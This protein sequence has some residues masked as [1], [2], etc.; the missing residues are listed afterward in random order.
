[1]TVNLP[2][3]PFPLDW[4]DAVEPPSWQVTD[5]GLE[6]TAAPGTDWYVYAPAPA[7]HAPSNGARLLGEPPAG[8]W[9]FSA[10]I[11]VDFNGTYDAG[12]LFLLADESHWSKLCFEYSPD[13]QGM[14]VS[15]VTRGISDDANAWNV[16][17]DTVWMRVS[18]VGEGF[19]FHASSDG[20][21]W[22]FVRCF[23]FGID[24]PIKAGFGVQAPEGQ[25]C[26]AQF[27]D[28]AFKQET[29]AELRNGS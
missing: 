26:K 9:Q 10:R 2:A 1:M 29:L 19:V 13:E 6:A 21:R 5:A 18:R 27:T 11:T 25:G 20:E 23:G 8:D 24:A 14:V 4:E 17:G 7:L 16:E 12:T 28:I 22:E 3:L 15:V